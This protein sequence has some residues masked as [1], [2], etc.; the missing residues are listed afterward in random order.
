MRLQ[1]QWAVPHLFAAVTYLYH[2]FYSSFKE[3]TG[4]VCKDN[5]DIC[6]D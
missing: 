3:D 6:C 2:S 4:G 1:M 5:N